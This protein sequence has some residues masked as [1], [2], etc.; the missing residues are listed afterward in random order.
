V[1]FDDRADGKLTVPRVSVIISTYN[2]DRFIAEAVESI[3]QQTFRRF[4]LIIVNDASSDSTMRILEGFD[5]D[6]ITVLNNSANLGIAASQNKAI[7]LAGGD[8]LA[9]MDHDDISLPERLQV[10]VDFLDGHPEV[11][12]VG[13]NCICIDENNIVKLVSVY[14]ADDA[15][16]KWYPLLC[17]CPFFHTS[18][19]IRRSAMERVGG[20]TGNY[21]FAGDYELI[22]KLTD[23][24]VVANLE[25]PLVKWRMHSAS[26]SKVNGQR[27]SDEALKISQQNVKAV[28]GNGELDED[29]WQGLRSLV[30]SSPTAEVNISSEQTNASISFLLNLQDKFY[31]RHGFATAT[32]KKHRRHVY[33]VWGRH[34]FALA[35]RRNGN[36]DPK[37]RFTLLKWAGKLFAGVVSSSQ[38][39]WVKA[40]SNSLAD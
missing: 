2:G 16:L 19:M 18:L 29:T 23:S 8:Y 3:L 35:F 30:M 24:C 32:I 13:S 1:N 38:I 26:T 22:S 36:R 15:F 12:M 40:V 28:L 21:L 14:P 7:A 31:R 27:L 17:G 33:W 39:N 20:Y 10:Q 11:G 5:D 4:E 6:R 9:L 34:F 25:Q 37:C